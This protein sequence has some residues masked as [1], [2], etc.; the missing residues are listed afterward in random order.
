MINQVRN[1]LDINPMGGTYQPCDIIP[2][3][4]V[5]NKIQQLIDEGDAHI[6]WL[7]G[8]AGTGKSAISQTVTELYE[9]Y[10]RKER[11]ALRCVLR[12]VAFEI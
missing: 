4:D 11:L 5:I 2:H 9:L 1:N 12:S 7:K 6:C 8:P 10:A 3:V